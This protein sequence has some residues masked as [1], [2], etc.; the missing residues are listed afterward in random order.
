M[1]QRLIAKWF[2]VSASAYALFLHALIMSMAAAPLSASE[3]SLTAALQVICSGQTTEQTD[4]PSHG[5][6]RV[7]ATP[8]A[9]CG[10]GHT[11]LD[12]PKVFAVVTPATI[13]ETIAFA[14]RSG[15]TGSVSL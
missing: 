15:V 11:C 1:P 7:H 3:N 4:L 5:Q 12:V 14:G 10:I 6:G 8:S 9:L 2:V 13:I